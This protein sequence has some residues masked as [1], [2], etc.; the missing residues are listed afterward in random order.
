MKNRFLRICPYGKK[1][2]D[3]LIFQCARNMGI[4]TVLSLIVLLLWNGMFE[5]KSVLHL[6]E[7]MILAV[8]LICMEVPNYYLQERENKVYNEL[9]LYF[10]R[11]KHRY[12]SCH[13]IA[14]AV[15]HAAEGMS[16]EIEQS[17]WEIYRLLLECNRKNKILAYME[18]HERN[19]YWKMFLIQAYEVS[20][21]GNIFFEENVEHIRLE[22]MEEIYRRRRRQYAYSGYVFVTVTPFFMLPVLKNW[23]LGFTPELEFFYAGTGRILETFI[24]LLTIAVYNL[25]NRA[26]EMTLF[27]GLGRER[28]L[29]FNTFYNI[30]IVRNFVRKIEGLEGKV[31]GMVRSLLL[32]AGET[33][34]FGRFCTKMIVLGITTVLIAAIFFTTNHWQERK[35]ILTRVDNIDEIAPVAGKEKKELLSGYILEITNLCKNN[36]MTDEETI[37]LLLRDR[38][39]LENDFTEQAVVDAVKVKL[40]MYSHAKGNFF[41]FVL[42]VF[43]GLGVGLFPL[44]QLVLQERMIRSEAE[45]EVKLFQAI[46]LMECRIPNMTVVR[47][48]EDMESFSNCFRNVLR[49]CINYYNSNAKEAML[50]LKKDGSVVH[51]GFE[52]LADAFLSV[53]EV[54]IENAFAE[55]EN[56]RRL[57]EK[58]SKLE[59]EVAQEKK[60][61]EL[62]LLAQLPMLISVGAYFILPFFAYSLESVFEVFK[63]L[64]EMKM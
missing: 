15:V 55:V 3:S 46:L 30:G 10:S 17:A 9:I 8:C 43:G 5:A 23:G 58:I 62:E 25:V 32:R 44:I 60:R 12:M 63:L 56:D 50:R 47:L 4:M 6:L 20:E 64:E 33:I 38:I 34:S 7:S 54:G 36:P 53:D 22:L 26:K 11:V 42:C 52:M 35:T 39:H 1:Q 19:R 28:I 49:R 16:Y 57:L 14:N 45:H 61:S 13:H 37:R 29:N 40:Q 21:N 2:L 24:F 18:E 27:S 48:L 31:S 59:A 51:E 41:E